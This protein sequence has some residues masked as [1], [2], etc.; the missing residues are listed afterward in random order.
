MRKF[1]ARNPDGFEIDGITSGF[2]DSKTG[3]IN[4]GFPRRIGMLPQ[5]VRQALSRNLTGL[6]ASVLPLTIELAGK[7]R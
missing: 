6:Y 5:P 2:N 4:R 7:I 1:P 3:R